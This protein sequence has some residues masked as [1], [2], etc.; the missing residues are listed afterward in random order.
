M[1]VNVWKLQRGEG[2]HVHQQPP[3]SK[4]LSL[5]Q[6]LGSVVLNHGPE[7]VQLGRD[8]SMA[9]NRAPSSV[10]CREVSSSSLKEKKN[11]SAGFIELKVGQPGQNRSNFFK[12]QSN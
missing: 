12:S 5:L 7:R 3:D 8:G 9:L 4:P 2:A 1:Y 6:L 11:S 10:A